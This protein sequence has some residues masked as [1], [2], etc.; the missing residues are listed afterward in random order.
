[1]SFSLRKDIDTS[2]P[3][4]I[5][6]GAI[7]HLVAAMVLSA[8]INASGVDAMLAMPLA[9][10]FISSPFSPTEMLGKLIPLKRR[11]LLRRNVWYK[12]LPRAG[13]S[14]Y[15]LTMAQQIAQTACSWGYL[16]APMWAVDERYARLLTICYINTS[17]YCKTRM[18]IK[19][20]NTTVGGCFLCRDC[21]MCRS[22]C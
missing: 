5:I 7:S 19:S 15:D 22:W 10:S 2:A 20:S 21:H 12:A 16:E 14:I 13:R 6:P 9:K 17:G 8:S 3:G 1:M 11:A 4:R 18:G